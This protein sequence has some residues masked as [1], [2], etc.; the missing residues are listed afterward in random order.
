MSQQTAAWKRGTALG[1]L[2][3]NTAVY[4][5]GLTLEDDSQQ[6]CVNTRSSTS[7]IY[8]RCAGLCTHARYVKLSTRGYTSRLPYVGAGTAVCRAQTIPHHVTGRRS[9]WAET[10][11]TH[12][13]SPTCSLFERLGFPSFSGKTTFAGCAG[14][15]SGRRAGSQRP[16]AGPG[17]PAGVHHQARGSAPGSGPELVERGMVGSSVGRRR[18]TATAFTRRFSCATQPTAT[19]TRRVPHI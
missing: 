6:L 10:W 2:E 17:G 16:A 13:W 1:R 9:D 5:E 19:H 12:R 18:S 15:G 14:T 11:Y 3:Y 4:N 7:S 8:M